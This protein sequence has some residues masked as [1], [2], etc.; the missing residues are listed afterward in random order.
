MQR[1]S[2]QMVD[3]VAAYR[4]RL[5]SAAEAVGL[6]A[7]GAKVAMALGAG[8]PPAILQALA[9]R[10]RS[11]GGLHDVRLYYMLSTAVAARTVL[12]ADL[13]DI[14][15]PVSIFHS[16]V[17]R[18]LDAERLKAQAPA[19]DFIPAAFQHVPR[20]LCEHVGVDTLIATVSPMDAD[21]WFSLGTNADYAHAVTRSG[22]K[23]ILEVNRHMP[24]V[25][26]EC[27]VHVSQVAALV[28]HDAP[29]LELPQ[30]ERTETDDRI[31]AII[32]GLIDDGAC[33]QMGIGALPDA[34]CERLAGHRHLGIHTEM[35]TSGLARLV[36]SGVVDNS[37]KRMHAGKTIYTFALGDGFLYDFLRTSPDVEAH[38]VEYV[39]DPAVIARN[40]G[41]VSVNATVQIDLHG[42]CNSEHIRGRQF[43][44]TGG[45]L[46]FVRGAYASKGGRSI[47]ACHSTAAGGKISRIV[48]VLE[49]PVT[50]P[51]TDTHIVVTE[52]GWAD[53]KGKT[54]AERAHALIGLAHPDFREGLE[55][56]AVAAG[57]IGRR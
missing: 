43:S 20:L 38:P 19:V 23:L 6:V 41:V 7:S 11:G 12:A 3:H 39:N 33:L 45:Q 40:D 50:T 46:D 2:L 32:A 1:K 8:A 36:A 27:L 31:G 18:A 10:A 52:Y 16:G 14:L 42:A 17:E 56:D 25:R 22:A 29:L 26:G 30:A 54:L 53:L 47:L 21:G 4:D 44:A 34:V 55:R 24:F 48:P 37:R 49:G 5:M 35:M 28:E 51:R 57:V 9:E 15:R 13:N